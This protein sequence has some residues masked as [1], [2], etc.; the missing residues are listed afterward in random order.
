MR[1][2]YLWLLATITGFIFLTGGLPP[3]YAQGDAESEFTLEEIIVTAEKREENVQK[4]SLSISVLTGD[5][6]KDRSYSSIDSMLQ[7]IA[8]LQIQGVGTS[9]QIFIRGIGLNNLDTAY[10]DP[11]IA[12]NVD[13]IQQLR[14]GAI[15][16]STMDVERVEVLRGP[17]GTMYG[18]SATGG[19]VNIVMAQ[20]KDSFEVSAGVQIGNYNAQTYEAMVN[21]PVYSKLALRLTGVK[22][23]RD[24]Y[25]TSTKGFQDQLTGR[26]KA[27]FKPNEDFTLTGTVEYRK[28]KSSG[29]W[30]SVPYSVLK[31]SD[32]PWSY[33]SGSSN[34]STNW[35]DSYN[36]SLNLVWNI[37]DLTT[38]TF[39]PA[40]STNETHFTTVAGSM[41][42]PPPYPKGSQYTYELRFAN[43]ADS[44]ATWT[45]GAYL[46][47]STV[48]NAE[49]ELS[50]NTGWNLAQMDRPT[51]SWAAFGQATY[52]I[53][54]RFRAT[55]GLRY[56]FDDKTQEFRIYYNDEEGNKTY[57]S[58]IRSYG[59]TLTKPTWKLGAEYDLSENSMSYFTVSEGYKS[60]GLTFD[61][62]MIQGDPTGTGF[63]IVDLASHKFD[64]ETS[65]A[66]ELGS[67]NRF[68]NDR[69]QINGAL[70][71]TAY[72]GLQVMMW[73]RLNEDNEDEDPVQFIAN[74]GKT[75]T[76][77]AEI[78][79]T[80]LATANDRINMSVSSMFGEYHDLVIKYDNPSW[81]GGG[82]NPPVDLEGVEMAN[83]PK[84]TL[85]L[86]YTRTFL[87]ADHGS[88]SATIGSTYKSKYYNGI[89]VTNSGA[90]VPGHHISNFYLSWTSP[91]GVW[92]ASANVK[93]IENKA[94]A[95]TASQR[96]VSLNA[97]RTFNARLTVKF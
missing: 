69:L 94:I 87:L 29:G 74:G 14:G 26:L 2:K 79:T 9:S 11:A 83:M 65:M 39:I 86:D 62:N 82:S 56:S 24:S 80:W 34:P 36:Y 70:F 42:P 35:T 61:Y 92:S 21:V 10:G 67:K 12:L 45:L 89:E 96:S 59:D 97:P 22:D 88:L 71:M 72:K 84:I 54:D 46:L 44:K 38:M 8:G 31:S 43:A 90:L 58:G 40:M 37:M 52:P 16:Q 76:Y 23:K 77:G 50:T 32:D 33:D 4:T 5:D 6:I 25:M 15:G 55:L 20:P 63:D 57:D 49:Q 7:N 3:S 95:V 51:G 73:K 81:A 78:E 19:A 13:G 1:K 47:D 66:Y 18:R 64:E 68:L 17:Q 75:N 91:K 93:N 41:E 27:Q 85:S 48:N 60:G 30:A 28:D 53:T